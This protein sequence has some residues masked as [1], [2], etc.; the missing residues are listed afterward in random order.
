MESSRKPART[1]EL[2]MIALVLIW[3]SNFA[4]VKSAVQQIQPLAFNALRFSAASIVALSLTWLAERDL[5]LLP[6]DRLSVLLLGFLSN[7]VY[8]MFFING[9]QRTRAGNSSLILAAVPIFVALINQ[10]WGRERLRIQNW[11]GIALASVGIALLV[12]GGKSTVQWSSQTAIGDL[13]TLGATISWAVYTVLSR[14][15]MSRNSPM[16]VTAWMMA[17]ATPWMVLVA[18]PDLQKQAWSSVSAQSWLGLVFSALLATGIGY[19]I[20]NTAVRQLGSARTSVYSFLPPLVAV[21]VAWILLGET[22]QMVQV[23][24]G[25][26]I[27]CGVALGRQQTHNGQRA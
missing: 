12:S 22:I 26:L 21:V 23:L 1:I 15:I 9:I 20:W 14:T 25:L 16:R 4:I 10:I 6:Q 19:F 3:G 18:I 5:S 13:L 8:Q 27:L 24:C 17:S 2:A 7:F 11:L